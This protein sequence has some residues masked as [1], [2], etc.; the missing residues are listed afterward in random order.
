MVLVAAP[1]KSS[2]PKERS[3]SA[4]HYRVLL[5]P[6][7]ILALAL[8]ACSSDSPRTAAKVK[9][10]ASNQSS[11]IDTDATIWSLLGFARERPHHE[12]GPKTGASV[13]PILWQAARETLGFVK[14]ASEDPETG[15][16]VTKWYSPQGKKEERFKIYVFVLNRTLRSDSVA[17]NILREERSP[18]GKWVLASIDK[19]L[20]SA[21]QLAIL[22]RATELRHKWYPH[23]E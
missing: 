6:A 10:V 15:E 8:G 13:N 23:E 19:S 1:G 11:G 3:M 14:S 5:A 4:L 7:A 21:L 16:L 18:E 20:D 22:R 17:V 2:A 12:P 9:Q